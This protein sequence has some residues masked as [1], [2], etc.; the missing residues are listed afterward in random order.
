[1]SKLGILGAAYK[2]EQKK[3]KSEK[4]KKKK[5]KI[6]TTHGR[7]LGAKID[8]REIQLRSK[9]KKKKNHQVVKGK[10]DETT[11]PKANPSYTEVEN[12]I[13]SIRL[14]QLLSPLKPSKS[15]KLYLN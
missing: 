3:S 13:I 11:D 10:K 12:Y 1:M 4:D 7:I 8:F 15:A 14:R 9:L 2:E 5:K 6:K